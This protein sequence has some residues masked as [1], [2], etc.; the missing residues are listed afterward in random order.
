MSL[1]DRFRKTFQHGDEK[2]LEE[3]LHGYQ[4]LG[5][6][7]YEVEVELAETENRKSLAFLQAAKCLKEMADALVHEDGVQLEARHLPEASIELAESWYGRIPDVIVAARREAAV[8]DSS[9]IGLPIRLRRSREALDTW[10]DEHLLGLRRAVHALQ[11]LLEKRIEHAEFRRDDNK[12]ALLYYQEA[13]TRQEA[14]DS[15]AGL[16]V[17]GE[18]VSDTS[19]QE[20]QNQYLSTLS[21]YVLIAQ[22]LEEPTVLTYEQINVDFAEQTAT[23]T[24]SELHNDNTGGLHT[25]NF[26]Q[27]QQQSNNIQQHN[28][29]I[30]NQ[31]Q[32][33]V[34][35]VQQI[36]ANAESKQDIAFALRELALSVR[37]LNQET[38]GLLQNMALY[39]QHLEDSHQHAEHYQKQY[40]P[41]YQQPQQP[42]PA[43]GMFGGRRGGGFWNTLIQSAELGAGF[44]IGA[45]IVND[46]FGGNGF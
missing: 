42:Q 1:F 45:D 16:L 15:I 8:P 25:M 18:E 22:G 19:R 10:S 3:K 4:R 34:G 26:E 31:L 37:G 21:S 44:E 38:M 6:Q 23:S 43:G 20:A 39:I 14:G 36:D 27:M 12:D 35:K 11:D 46:I 2:T 9:E 5:E 24:R 30:V 28:T 7:V 13:R 33:I 32:Q 40:P 41:Q 17:Q 29:T